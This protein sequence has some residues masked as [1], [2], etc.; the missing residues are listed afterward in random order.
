VIIPPRKFQDADEDA[1][2]KSDNTDNSTVM[3]LSRDL[4]WKMMDQLNPITDQ[5]PVLVIIS[6]LTGPPPLMLHRLNEM[7]FLV[8]Q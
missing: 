6:D 1:S 2:N 3:P 4:N 5:V 7:G 8:K